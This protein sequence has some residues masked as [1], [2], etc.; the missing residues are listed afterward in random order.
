MKQKATKLYRVALTTCG[1]EEDAARLAK[2]LVGRRLAACVN[3][4][5]GVRSFYWWDGC[6][7]EDGELLL[8]MKTRVEVLPELE[9]AVREL[10]P[11]DVPEFVVLPIVAGS[12]AYLRWIDDNVRPIGA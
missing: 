2:E 9:A 6:V 1:S 7:Q 11:Y 4:V 10:H 8:V 3:I 5:P 12:A